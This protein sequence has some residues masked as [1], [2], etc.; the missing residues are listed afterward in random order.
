MHS[1]TRQ[2]LTALGIDL[3]FVIAFVALGRDTHG[4]AALVDPVGYLGALWPFGVSLLLASAAVVVLR[5]RTDGIAAGLVVW[6]VTLG[7]GM[8]LRAVSGQGTALPF[9]IVAAVTLLVT[10]VGWRL[11][12]AVARRVR[13]ARAERR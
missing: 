10:L 6:F 11:V 2:P 9:V 12:L 4:D 13:A 3:A 1:A 5:G 8:L 7:G